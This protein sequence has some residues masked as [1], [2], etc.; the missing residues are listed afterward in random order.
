MSGETERQSRRMD[1]QTEQMNRRRNSRTNGQ[2]D[3]RTVGRADRTDGQEA[4]QPNE[5]TNG[6]TGGWTSRQSGQNRW[7]AGGT[8]E[9]MDKRTVGRA[10]RADRTGQSRTEQTEQTEQ[11]EQAERRSRQAKQT[12]CRHL[13]PPFGRFA[14]HRTESCRRRK[15]T[16]I[17]P[18]KTGRKRKPGADRTEVETGSRSDESGSAKKTIRNQRT[19]ISVCPS[20][21]TLCDARQ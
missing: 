14:K 13:A 4:K 5:W 11:D 19:I 7:T 6:Q 8:A 2:T 15:K 12:D 1:E 9:R 21:L 3:K 16:T 10:D 20:A 18:G 17:R